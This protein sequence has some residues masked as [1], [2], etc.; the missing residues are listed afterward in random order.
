MI[1]ILLVVD[2]EIPQE[3]FCEHWYDNKKSSFITSVIKAGMIILK[4]VFN[5]L[6]SIL[7]S[8]Q[9]DNRYIINKNI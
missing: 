6:I 2:G 8:I 1:R 4:I 5:C 9:G 3:V 7:F